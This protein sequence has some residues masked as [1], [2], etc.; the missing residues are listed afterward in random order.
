ML[1]QIQPFTSNCKGWFF[2]L[3]S[4]LVLLLASCGSQT[5]VIPPSDQDRAI[6]QEEAEAAVLKLQQ[7]AGIQADQAENF[8][9]L[10]NKQFSDAWSTLSEREQQ[11][12][13]LFLD[14]SSEESG[15]SSEEAGSGSGDLEAQRR[16]C[17][18]KTWW[19]TG[20]NFFGKRL[21]QYNQRLHWCSNGRYLTSAWRE[22][23]GSTH[24][25]GWRFDD[26]EERRRTIRG[27]RGHTYYRVITV[28]HVIYGIG[29]WDAQHYYP[30]IDSVVYR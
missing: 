9:A 25:I 19:V 7:N 10:S 14:V 30:R 29:G 13:K 11:A 18:Y 27:G 5:P 17:W 8:S 26:P 16:G 2:V 23:W 1:K 3:C 4:A 28:G 24:W 22:V 12:A 20:K 6:S 15:M 21:W